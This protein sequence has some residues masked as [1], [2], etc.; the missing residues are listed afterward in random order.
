MARE[1]KYRC[2][3]HGRF[4]VLVACGMGSGPAPLTVPCPMCGEPS[5]RSP[6]R[7]AELNRRHISVSGACY[8]RLQKHSERTG[9]SVPNLVD[10]LTQERTSSMM[11]TFELTVATL[12]PE[13]IAVLRALA[14]NPRTNIQPQRRKVFVRLGL[15]MPTEP[16][17]AAGGKGGNGRSKPMARAHALTELGRSVLAKEERN[18]G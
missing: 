1:T 8:E 11:S 14:D 5:I 16:P 13:H 12:R 6:R 3:Q 18:A 9:V 2:P 7:G 15:I 4:A 10:A 17:R